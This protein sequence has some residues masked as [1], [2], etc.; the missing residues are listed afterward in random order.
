MSQ[1]EE[2]F[3]AIVVGAGLAGIACAYRLAQAGR[4]VVLVERGSSPGSKNV[5]GGRLYTYALEEVEDGLTRE[6]PWERAV[7]REQMI[8]MD[9]DRSMAISLAPAPAPAPAGA[10]PAS[11]TVLR[12]RFD[13]W[14]AGKAA[15]AGAILAAGVTV[16]SLIIESGR[17]VGIVAGG[18][19][20]R[21]GV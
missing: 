19:E 9:A 21:A 1:D 5:S 12:S 4:S 6:A 16:D 3:D 17:V 8:V 14:F 20:M 18:E 15:D 7:V 10:L 11:V 13:E 2:V